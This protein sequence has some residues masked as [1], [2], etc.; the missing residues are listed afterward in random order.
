MQVSFFRA[1]RHLTQRFGES[2]TTCPVRAQKDTTGA[3]FYSQG[4]GHAGVRRR[5]QGLLLRDGWIMPCRAKPLASNIVIYVST[6]LHRLWTY[7]HLAQNFVHSDKV[8]RRRLATMGGTITTGPHLHLNRV[9][10]CQQQT[11]YEQWFWLY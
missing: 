6:N 5:K 9:G 10:G 3:N 7:A 4:C 2:Q 11:E 1:V 8:L